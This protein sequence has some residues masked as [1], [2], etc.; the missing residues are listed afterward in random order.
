MADRVRFTPNR[1][2][3]VEIAAGPKMAAYLER[4]AEAAAAEVDRRASSI[5]KHR[6]SLI[7]GGVT[8]TAAGAEGRVTV[9]SPFWH[10]PEHGSSRF[11]PR[12]YIRPGVQAVLSRVGGRW[13]SS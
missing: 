7:S 5:V 2:A 8:R 10:L 1:R 11:P 13:K 3:A 9:K 6:G 12:P 4:V